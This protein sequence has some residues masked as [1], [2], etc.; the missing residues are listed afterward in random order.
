MTFLKTLRHM[1]YVLGI[2]YTAAYTATPAL[3]APLASHPR[4][5]VTPSDLPRLR[6]WAVPSNPIYQN[7]LRA[8][9]QQGLTRMDRA[10]T[11]QAGDDIP[12]DDPGGG[13]YSGVYTEGWAGLFS[14]MAL[15][16]P[17]AAERANYANHGKALLMHIVN[18]VDGDAGNCQTFNP[19]TLANSGQEPFCGSS[20][21]IS[22]RM[23]WVQVSLPLA[24]DWLQGYGQDAG[25]QFFTTAEKAAIRRVF[26]RWVMQ[27]M[28]AY[29]NA[30][31][32]SARGSCNL[33]V[34]TT[35]DALLRLAPGVDRD[36]YCKRYAFNNYFVGHMRQIGMMAM[37]IDS[38]D[39]VP[40]TNPATMN[41]VLANAP[42]GELMSYRNDGINGWLHMVNYILNNDGVGGQPPEGAE[43]APTSGGIPT[44][45]L[46]ALSTANYADAEGISTWGTKVDFGGYS[47]FKD[48][49]R[50]YLHQMGPYP[51]GT[52]HGN[53]YQ[54]AWFGDGEHIYALDFMDVFGPIGLH[55]YNKVQANAPDA[56]AYAQQL[57]AVRWIQKHI[58][59]G[60]ANAIIGRAS[61][62]E[63]LIGAVLYFML[64]DPAAPEPTD[65]RTA[66]PL[67]YFARGAGR[68]GG[69]TSWN[70]TG[71][72]SFNY[73]LGY[74]TIDHQNPDGNMF[75]F[76]RKG[77]WLTK[78]VTGY[79]AGGEA[80]RSDWKNTLTIQND[81]STTGISN[82]HHRKFLE[83]GNQWVLGSAAG[84]PAILARSVRSDLMY[85]M[86]DATN[87]YNYCRFCWES[88]G[89]GRNDVQ[90]ASRSLVWIKPDV[91][92]IYDRA[93]TSVANR[94]KRFWLNL[95]NKNVAN[96]T[97]AADN[98]T[99]P[100]WMDVQAGELP[101]GFTGSGV[102]PTV[103]PDVASGT[104]LTTGTS[105]RGQKLFVRT[106][107]PQNAN[108][109]ILNQPDCFGDAGSGNP[110]ID[111]PA[112]GCTLSVYDAM[113][114]KQLPGPIQYRMTY[115]DGTGTHQQNLLYSTRLRVEA[116]NN[117]ANAR[118]L[119]VVEG[120]DPGANATPS[121]RIS[122]SAGMAFDGAV[123]ANRAILFPV[124]VDYNA[125][126]ATTTYTV[127]ANAPNQ[128]V[129]G[130]V[131]NAKYNAAVTAAG[132]NLQITLTSNGTQHTADGGG[133]LTFTASVAP[134]VS[135]RADFNADG[136]SDMLW[137][138]SATGMLYQVQMNGFTVGTAAVIDQETD[139]N[140]KV[141]AVADLNGD[142]RADV[143]W[144]H[145]T[146]GQVYGVL[147]D[148]TTVLSEGS[149]YVE[150]NT[151]WKVV[152][153]GD[154]NADGRADLLWKNDA[155][156]DVFLLLLN[157]L[158]VTSGGVIYSEPNT[159]WQIQKVADFNGDG[160][161][162]VLWRNVATG[163][164]FVLLMNG[165]AV[166]GGGV[167]Y[168]EPNT[169]WQIQ[170][171]ADFNGDGRADVLWRNTATGDVFMMLM[172]GTTITGGSVFYGE[173][174]ADWKIVATGDYNGDGRA[175]ILWRNTAT[176]QVFMM[177][178]NGFAI[179]GGDFVYAEPDQNWKVLG[180]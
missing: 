51:V 68:F 71:L 89:T 32:Y 146:T 9:A 145:G 153:A 17:D 111:D 60:G 168:S 33:P 4:L 124:D 72:R 66:W 69:R 23:R 151:Q 114:Q 44:H 149:I 16:H 7:G 34:R 1:M 15:A 130:L 127:P 121:T 97:M 57:N 37:S 43:Y 78:E 104:I 134:V 10:P 18:R 21:S 28:Q 172:N 100:G 158:A 175:D 122:S 29:P 102:Q 87:L 49:P 164:V 14:F 94:F 92:V 139:L 82:Y 62:D 47:F 13:A 165:T 64:Y 48:L 140:W 8:L 166:I 143:V 75:D 136:R 91:F 133:V 3:A 88:W 178:M 95:P 128:I 174:N 35:G 80:G 129:T 58:P 113:T 152:G 123:V 173:P 27:N 90:H 155:T 132:G 96:D 77:E 11:G 147:M 56:A 179:S 107:L 41:K 163:D 42:A 20:F 45:F 40:D 84:D 67:D 19:S 156:G 177:L 148:G 150:P 5:W 12:E 85:V 108:A 26:L 119:H 59:P 86:G 46:L 81:P 176:G 170:A 103:V 160:R 53:A 171:A 6:S 157:G 101:S 109:S 55:A 70:A 120:A 31:S 141:V 169:A 144:Q 167:I 25:V 116:P 99:Y 79:G 38:V 74:T 54:P 142:G 50:V 110:Q 125:A 52:G 73:R 106:L 63:E 83:N 36:R 159:S 131:P 154:F 117:P 180:P 93:R 137:H 76:F 65:P 98:A 162:D 39:D 118:F 61:D 115:T 112:Y 24:Y 30:Y 161:A 138:N 105:P 126:F 135:A 2:G 22:D